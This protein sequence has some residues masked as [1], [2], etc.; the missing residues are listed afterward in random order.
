MFSVYV[1]S[2]C[3]VYILIIEL[4]VLPCPSGMCY[5]SVTVYV[6]HAEIKDNLLT[7]LNRGQMFGVANVQSRASSRTEWRRTYTHGETEGERERGREGDRRGE[8]RADIHARCPE[9]AASRT[10]PPPKPVSPAPHLNRHLTSGVGTNF[11]VGGHGERERITEVW[12]RSAWSG[13]QGAEAERSESSW[14]SN[15]NGTIC[16]LFGRPILQ[17]VF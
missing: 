6:W 8:P 10:L 4:A 2:V 15:L 9:T 5:K 12:W 3:C 17:T 7:Y 16:F 13:D 14:K 1:F 11:R